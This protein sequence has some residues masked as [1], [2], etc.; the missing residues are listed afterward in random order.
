MWELHLGFGV[1]GAEQ[2]VGVGVRDHDHHEDGPDENE[3]R[4]QIQ[5]VPTGTHPIGI[6]YVNA[7]RE[8][9]VACYSGRIMVFHDR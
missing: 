2:K 5:E 3:E 8:V 1:G 6:T 7:T 9:W 4:D